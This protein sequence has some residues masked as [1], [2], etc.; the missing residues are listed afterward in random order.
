[1]GAQVSAKPKGVRPCDLD[2]DRRECRPQAKTPDCFMDF[3]I[4]LGTSVSGGWGGWVFG[5]DPES[6]ALCN[7]LAPR[8]FD[9][10]RGER[11]FQVE[12]VRPFYQFLDRFW[13]AGCL[14]MLGA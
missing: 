5:D 6:M 14:G 8:D 12:N 1:M 9:G 7:V 2:G 11:Q 4:V 3:R 10:R 13:D